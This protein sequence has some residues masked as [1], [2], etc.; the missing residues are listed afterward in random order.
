MR[1]PIRPA[2]VAAAAALTSLSSA[3]ALVPTGPADILGTGLMAATC[4]SLQ[5][6]GNGL[7]IN[8][9]IDS[10]LFAAGTQCTGQLAGSGS[11]SS[12]AAWSNSVAQA[13]AAA[14]ATPGLLRLSG[15]LQ[16]PGADAGGGRFPV[17]IAQAAF[18]DM[19]TVDLAG[20]TGQQGF[21]LV[22][23]HV[24]ALLDAS[25][26]AGS[27][28]LAVALTKDNQ[29][30]SRALPGYD[31]GTGN[32]GSTD[33]QWPAWAV[34]SYP[35][36]GPVHDQLAVD[37]TVTFSLP[38]T[39]GTSFEMVVVGLSVA[40]ARSRDGSAL[41]TS[42]ASHT[43]QWLGVHGLL[44]NGQQTTGYTLTSGSGIDWTQAAAVPE[45]AAWALMA[46]GLALLLGQRRRQ[47]PAG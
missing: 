2:A 24:G 41:S 46:G 20:H 42:D 43:I 7:A 12:A 18:G 40:G 5:G 1:L 21:L 28:G 14:S 47:Q 44:V 35:V 38:V 10:G 16:T 27:A 23:L 37:E 3:W 45:P 4:A 17:A 32:A 11:A 36:P 31:S 8:G 30:L 25:R 33:Q 9:T 6:S 29:T 15:S 39:F 19:L 26:A 22:D 13:G 34:A